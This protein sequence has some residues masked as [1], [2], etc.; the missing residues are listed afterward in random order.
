MDS[1]NSFIGFCLPPYDH[2][3]SKDM[4]ICNESREVKISWWSDFPQDMS[5]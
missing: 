1:N 4:V 2:G 5:F 3:V